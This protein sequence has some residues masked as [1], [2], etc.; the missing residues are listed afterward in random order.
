MFLGA[1]EGKRITDALHSGARPRARIVVR[2]GFR[3]V[4]TPTVLATLPGTSSQRIVIDSHT[5]G[6]NAVEDNGPVAMVAMARYFATLPRA[7]RPRTLEFAFSTA[8]F[9]QRVANPAV[10]DGGAEQLAERLDRDYDKG[11]VS[12]VLVLEHLGARDYEAFPRTHGPGGVLRPNGLRSIQFIGVT[13]SPSLVSAVDGVVRGYDMQ[14][15]IVLQGADAPGGTVPSHCSFGGE[16]SPF[17]HHLL[18][19][20]GVIAAP[21]FLYDPAFGLNAIDFGVTHSELL[22]FTDLVLRLGTMSQTAVAGSIPAERAQRASG[23]PTC[24]QEN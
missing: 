10:R 13:P 4:V 12:S 18:P 3:H 9:F 5:D 14:R 21:Q 17:N 16:G 2:G 6:T 11:S 7:C 8:H 24:P 1:D 23:S 20:I 22:G 19:T 15:T